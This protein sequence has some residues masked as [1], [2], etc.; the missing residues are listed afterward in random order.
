M[1]WLIEQVHPENGD[2][3]LAAAAS[4]AGH[5]VTLLKPE[6]DIPAD[7]LPAGPALFHGSMQ[8]AAEIQAARPD[9]SVWLDP[10]P[11]ECCSYFP[12][13]GEF[14]F[15]STYIMLPLSELIRQKWTVYRWLAKD[16]KIFVRPSSG[17]KTFTG[18]LLDLQ[19]FDRFW[20]N[21]VMCNAQ[22]EDMV[23]VAAPKD[24]LGEW[25]F[26]ADKAG[27]MIACSTYLYQENRTYL[28]SAPEGAVE[29]CRRV[30]KSGFAPGPM[31]VL[32]IAGTP[33]GQ[34]GLLEANAFSTAAL[35]ACRMDPI[36]K[37]A[38][39]ILKTVQAS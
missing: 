35:Y 13:V 20:R 1:R 6:R 33:D 5:E 32:D 37:R 15:N 36:V 10:P 17:L 2:D 9:L 34:F 7:R 31:F 25:R 16:T 39:E 12:K 23:V 3:A 22:P 27:E 24:I 14:L 21:P 8:K 38:G 28:P 4:Q 29:L 30:L 19:D 11:F 26:V 18:T